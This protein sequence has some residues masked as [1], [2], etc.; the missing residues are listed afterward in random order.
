MIHA[1]I[2]LTNLIFFA[3]VISKAKPLSDDS[4]YLRD[5]ALFSSFSELAF[6]KN[7]WQG[8]R[9]TNKQTTNMS[10]TCTFDI[11]PDTDGFHVWLEDGELKSKP[12]SFNEFYK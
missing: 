8:D 12:I 3:W 1:L 2:I 9:L 5:C 6:L 7:V 4:K 11:H 10:G